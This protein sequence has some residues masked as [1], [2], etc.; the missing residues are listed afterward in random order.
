MLYYA[1]LALFLYDILKI[2]TY[3]TSFYR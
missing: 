1:N 3:N 2:L